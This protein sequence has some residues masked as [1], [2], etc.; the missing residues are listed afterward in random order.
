MSEIVIHEYLDTSGRSLFVRWF[1]GLNAAAAARVTLSVGRLEQGNFSQVKGVGR[2]I[3]ELKV[4]FGPGYRVYFGKEGERV[5]ILVGGSSKDRQG[6]AI[7]AAQAAW[8]DFK[9]RKGRK[10]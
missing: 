9:R 7:A 5:V 1:N 8:E 2:G 10:E 6:E 3:F 4:D